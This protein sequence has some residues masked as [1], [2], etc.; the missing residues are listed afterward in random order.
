MQGKCMQGPSEA[1]IVGVSLRLITTIAFLVV[2]ALAAHVSVAGA[3]L[4]DTRAYEQATPV[5]KLGSNAQGG[6]NQVQ[7][8]T[9]GDGIEFFSQSTLPGSEGAQNFGNYLATRSS[10][11]WTTQGLLPPPST[12]VIGRVQGWA[13]NMSYAYVVNGSEES[14]RIFYARNNL[15]RALTPIA[16]VGAPTIDGTSADGSQLLFEEGQELTMGAAEEHNLYLWDQSAKT[17]YLAGALNTGLAPVGGVRAASLGEEGTYRLGALSENGEDVYFTAFADEQL[18]LRQNVRQPQS[19]L[20]GAGECVDPTAACTVKVS[21]SQRAI[22]DPEGVKPSQYLASSSQGDP[23]VFFTSS[24]K[25]TDNATTGPGDAGNDLYR[26]DAKT[27]TLEDLVPDGV[28]NGAEVQGAL[29]ASRDGT[30]IYFVANGVLGDGASK[31]ATTGTCTAVATQIGPDECNLYFWEKGA[32]TKFISRLNAVGNQSKS[33][34]VDWVAGS[35]GVFLG[36]SQRLSRVSDDGEVA[37][38]RSQLRLTTYPNE[39]TPEYYMYQ[40]GGGS[41]LTCVTCSPAGVPPTSLPTLASVEA[42]GTTEADHPILTRNLSGSGSRFIFETGDKLVAGDTNGDI[43]CPAF[44]LPFSQ[45]PK[46]QDVYE[47]EADGTGSCSSQN[48]DGG[49]IFLISTGTSDEPSFFADADPTGQNIFFYTGQPLVGQDRDRL[50]DIYDARV[51]GGLSGQ[52]FTPLATCADEGTCRAAGGQAPI[53]PNPPTLNSSGKNQRQSLRCGRGLK[54][55]K[56]HGNVRC[57]KKHPR[58]RPGNSKVGGVK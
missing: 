3:E 37:V 2:A 6:I 23:V 22:K 30:R 42:F 4:P 47:W 25:L 13:E 40:A 44:S 1:P 27:Q 48:E 14:G 10:G 11:E 8:S 12:G 56:R 18:Y 24:G 33:D 21:E 51:G 20:N 34:H 38:F 29:G 39:G 26:Y 7:A 35:A 5:N 43:E 46:C 31:G 9:S 15:T 36:A 17:L 41:K 55:V 45:V 54:K 16:P 52:E 53:A 50:I 58:K 32:E 19:L 57:V 49:C 28:G